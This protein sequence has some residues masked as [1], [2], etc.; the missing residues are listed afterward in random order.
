[1]KVVARAVPFHCTTDD[2]AKLLPLTLS[3][4]AAPPAVALLG[5]SELSAGTG[6]AVVKRSLRSVALAAS[7][8]NAL[9]GG[10]SEEHTSELQS[11]TNLVCRLLLEKKHEH[12]VA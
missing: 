2:A 5:A 1:M 8:R 11:L 3:V 6:F 10:R 7:R 12:I 4:E 9:V